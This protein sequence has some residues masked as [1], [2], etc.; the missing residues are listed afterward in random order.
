MLPPLSLSPLY[1][2]SKTLIKS[3]SLSAPTQLNTVGEKHKTM[4]AYFS[5][6]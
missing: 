1:S 2:F 4:L 5:Y 6:N 3:M